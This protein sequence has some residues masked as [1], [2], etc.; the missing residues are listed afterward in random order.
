ML[1][2]VI[3]SPIVT[4]KSLHPILTKQIFSSVVEQHQVVHREQR[5][6][7]LDADAAARHVVL[8]LRQEGLPASRG[9]EDRDDRS[10]QRIRCPAAT[11]PDVE[12][13]GGGAG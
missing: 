3:K 7:R 9:H 6:Q 10:G 2:A 4:F 13:M 8:T 1:T 11:Y 5:E 12:R